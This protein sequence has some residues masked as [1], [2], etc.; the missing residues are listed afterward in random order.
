MYTFFI[1]EKRNSLHSN[2]NY[3]QKC[4]SIKLVQKSF[5]LIHRRLPET[6][7]SYLN[8]KVKER[9]ISFFSHHFK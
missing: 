7:F 2:Q 5:L 3:T 8:N 1:K 9:Y 6:V 4:D